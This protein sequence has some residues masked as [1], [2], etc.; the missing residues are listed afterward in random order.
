[1]TKKG[2]PISYRYQAMTTFEQGGKAYIFGVHE[3]KY[4]NIWRVFEDDPAKGFT[5]EYYGRNK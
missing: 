3:E 1:M 4:A 2:V 5:L